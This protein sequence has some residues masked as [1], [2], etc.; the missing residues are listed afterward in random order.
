[1]HHLPLTSLHPGRGRHLRA[2]RSPGQWRRRSEPAAGGK[3]RCCPHPATDTVAW[4]SGL[5]HPR[6]TD[7][8]RRAHPTPATLPRSATWRWRSVVLGPVA[9]MTGSAAGSSW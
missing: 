6:T 4:S 2:R 9:P 8:T 1:V 3:I 7:E 5:R